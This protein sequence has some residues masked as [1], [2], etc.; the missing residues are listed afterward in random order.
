M[1]QVNAHIVNGLADQ[2]NTHTQLLDS[3]DDVTR[4]EIDR[5]IVTRCERQVIQKE[6]AF[7]AD[8]D[9]RWGLRGGVSK[10]KKPGHTAPACR[11][12]ER[13]ELPLYGNCISCGEEGT[14]PRTANVKKIKSYE[15]KSKE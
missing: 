4:S 10:A 5:I 1:Q 7:R 9:D 2:Y 8:G 15:Y 3:D 11:S 12:V 6:V 14:T 13:K